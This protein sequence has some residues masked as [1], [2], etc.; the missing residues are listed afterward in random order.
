[1]LIHNIYAY[2]RS[3]VVLIE[4]VLYLTNNQTDLVVLFLSIHACVFYHLVI[5][6]ISWIEF[7]GKITATVPVPKHDG[8]VHGLSVD[9][10]RGIYVNCG[11]SNRSKIAILD[12]VLHLATEFYLNSIK[13]VCQQ[14]A[15]KMVLIVTV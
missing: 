3:T 11:I 4:S 5:C 13:V 8:R 1:M 14:A 10:V 6:F 15:Y 12:T 7:L 2:F 9:D